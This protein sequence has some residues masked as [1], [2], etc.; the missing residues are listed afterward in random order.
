MCAVKVAHFV[1]LLRPVLPSPVLGQPETHLPVQKHVQL[2]AWG[3]Y[4][5]ELKGGGWQGAQAACIATLA[6]LQNTA[7]KSGQ[8]Q[9][10]TVHHQAN[11]FST[12]GPK[13]KILGCKPTYYFLC[14]SCEGLCKFTYVQ[15]GSCWRLKATEQ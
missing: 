10:K 5:A 15:A 7:L 13:R 8:F 2:Q 9:T 14:R 11:L 1:M 3:A 4:Q 6:M 12:E